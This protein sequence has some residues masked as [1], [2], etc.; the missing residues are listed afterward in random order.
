MNNN[1]KAEKYKENFELNYTTLLGYAF[2][3]FYY[4]GFGFLGCL[5]AGYHFDR[6][7]RMTNYGIFKAIVL[8]KRW[9]KFFFYSDKK[10]GIFSAALAIEVLGY[11]NLFMLLF[12]KIF[13]IRSFQTFRLLWAI[14]HLIIFALLGVMDIIIHVHKRTQRPSR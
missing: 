4:V 1:R 5:F 9:R 6:E 3:T 2:L 8:P 11:I 10:N 7:N 13:F 14:S 12:A